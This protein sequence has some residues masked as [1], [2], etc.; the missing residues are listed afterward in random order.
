MAFRVPTSAAFH[1]SR[2]AKRR[3]HDERE[4]RGRAAAPWVP[5]PSF[6]PQNSGEA[7]LAS[8]EGV[9]ERGEAVPASPEAVPENGT[10][11]S[12][13]RAPAQAEHQR[14]VCHDEQQQQP[15]CVRAKL[16]R[17]RSVNTLSARRA[18]AAPILETAPARAGSTQGP[19][20][21][22]APLHKD[23]FVALAATLKHR[24]LAQMALPGLR[25]EA[26]SR[27]LGGSALTRFQDGTFCM[28]CFGDVAR[29]ALERTSPL[30]ALTPNG[31]RRRAVAVP[32]PCL[33][34]TATRPASAPAEGRS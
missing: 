3:A 13:P 25:C 23:I 24:G 15:P 10:D 29:E 4:D 18:Q 5:R 27:E 17:V 7:A 32:S 11:A 26:C 30:C 2:M 28:P 14:E 22:G 31:V 16:L 33:E 8:G 12:S 34:A 21:G 1:F 9:P 19:M 20:C 6:L